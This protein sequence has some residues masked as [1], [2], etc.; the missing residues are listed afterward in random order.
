M[1]KNPAPLLRKKEA[2]GYLEA[3]AICSFPVWMFVFTCF[4]YSL[5][6]I[7]LTTARLVTILI[8]SV[9]AGLFFGVVM[10]LLLWLRKM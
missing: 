7:E 1:E 8:S 4:A 3:M 6:N 9:V 10:G 2:A 5:Q